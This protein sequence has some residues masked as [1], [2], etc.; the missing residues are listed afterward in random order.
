M[1]HKKRIYS[2]LFSV[3]ILL[4]LNIL[5]IFSLSVL[6]HTSN[7]FFDL[8]H[9]LFWYSLSTIMVILIWFLT[10]W[11]FSIKNIPVYTDLRKII[12]QIRF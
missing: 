8:T 5:R 2:I 10:V 1:A 3:L 7:P 12:K 4:V 6:Y 11:I 9:K